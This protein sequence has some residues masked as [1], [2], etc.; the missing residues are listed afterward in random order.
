MSNNSKFERKTKNIRNINKNY[1][2]QN[3]L[4]L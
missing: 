4:N 1:N 2:F 3:V